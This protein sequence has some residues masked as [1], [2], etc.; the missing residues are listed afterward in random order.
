MATWTGEITTHHYQ[1]NDVT[2]A[3]GNSSAWTYWTTSTADAGTCIWTDWSGDAGADN[4]DPLTRTPEEIRRQ[5]LHDARYRGVEKREGK[6]KAEAENRAKKLLMEL[7]GKADYKKFLQL[8]YLD[9]EGNSGKTYR[10][11]PG[12]RIEVLEKD[13]TI[14]SL[15]ITTPNHYLPKFDEIIW[16]K[17]LA[18]T[19]EELLLRVANHL[20]IE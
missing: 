7:I 20:S 10:I 13:I 15:C 14:E 17:L 9:V 1:N 5:R 12:R 11:R 2:S 8:E 18:E 3:D 6:Q 16:K 4:Q 19:N